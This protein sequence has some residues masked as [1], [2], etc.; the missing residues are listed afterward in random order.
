MGASAVTGQQSKAAR[1]R[2]AKGVETEQR[3]LGKHY[4]ALVTGIIDEDEVSQAAADTPAYATTTWQQHS[5]ALTVTAAVSI[6][7]AV[8]LKASPCSWHSYK[9]Q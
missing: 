7:A 3:P 4:R 9:H 1:R 8:A 2:A 5:L 6:P